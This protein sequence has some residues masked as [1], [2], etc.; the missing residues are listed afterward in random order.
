MTIDTAQIAQILLD[1]RGALEWLTVAVAIIIVISSTDDFFIDV[2][3]WIRRMRRRLFVRPKFPPLPLAKL[4]EKPEQPLAIMVPAWKESDVIAAMLWT[5]T[6]LIRYRNYHFFVGTYQNDPAT[7]AEVAKV[8]AHY[9]NVHCVTVPNDGPTCKADCLNTIIA[10]IHDFEREHGTEFAG[11]AMHDAEDIIHPLELRFFNFLID[12]KDLIQLPI[13]SLR[14]PPT[15]IVAGTYMDEFAEWHTKD[16]V[17]RESMTGTVPCAGVAAC[18]SRRAIN[19]LSEETGGAPFNTSTLTEDYDIA[20]R[21]KKLGMK[22]V[23]VRFPV[24][25]AVEAKHGG[26]LELVDRLGPIATKEYFPSAFVAA[27]RQRARWILGIAFH[28]WKSIGWRASWPGRYFLLRDRKTILTSPANMIAM[29]LVVQFLLVEAALQ[30]FPGAQRIPTIFET[31]A[32][33]QTLMAI[34]FGF[35]IL[36]LFHRVFFTTHIYG[37]VHGMLAIPRLLVS[38]LVNYFAVSRAIGV[39]I[40]SQLT[41]RK[42]VWDKTTHTFPTGHGSVVAPKPAAQPEGHQMPT[43]T[44]H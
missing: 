25:E 4:A 1:Y 13:F 33:M 28:G 7:A 30:F 15:A 35:L 44:A 3:Y 18:F 10:G 26:G 16:L 32:A 5:N 21:L 36:R 9:P 39:Y 24:Q 38:N 2:Y 11:I 22:E 34:N 17:V 19:A 37:A 8:A 43:A 14:C 20:F 27:Y 23:F 12:R 42:I 6:E 40:D 31:S 41:G 29:F